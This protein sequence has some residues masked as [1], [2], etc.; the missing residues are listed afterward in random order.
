[1]AQN[2]IDYS[3]INNLRNQISDLKGKLTV[4][5]F[6]VTNFKKQDLNTIENVD[7]LKIRVQNL[8]NKLYNDIKDIERAIETKITTLEDKLTRMEE[9]M[10]PLVN[11]SFLMFTK[12]MDV[13]KWGAILGIVVSILTSV[14]VLDNVIADNISDSNINER[15]EQLLELSE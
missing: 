11:N 8:E 5:D 4:M 15:I 12:T 10:D 1:M 13:K 7:K 9:A 2:D 6:F 3:E 14:G